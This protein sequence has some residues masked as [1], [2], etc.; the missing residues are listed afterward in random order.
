MKLTIAQPN[1]PENASAVLIDLLASFLKNG[2]LTQDSDLR[3]SLITN[4]VY[5]DS[6]DLLT[7]RF[8]NLTIT[9]ISYYIRFADSNV[10][11]ALLNAN[12]GDG[13]GITTSAAS[14][15][16]IGTLFE[17]NNDIVS[18]NEFKYFRRNNTNTSYKIN[19][20]ANLESIDLSECTYYPGHTFQNLPK[21]EYFGGPNSEP[22]VLAFPEGTTTIGYYGS[23]SSLPKLKH[24]IFPSTMRTF[25]ANEFNGCNN[26][27]SITL[28]EGFQTFGGNSL[29]NRSEGKLII[30]DLDAFLNIT[31]APSNGT[32]NFFNQC[33]YF[34][35]KDSNG[36]LTEITSFTVPQTMLSIP[37]ALFWQCKSL[38][39][40]VFHSSITTIERDA[41]ADCVN[42]IGENIQFPNLTVLGLG[43]FHNC[44]IISF[45]DLGSITT[46]SEYTF[47]SNTSLTTV[48]IPNSV[49]VIKEFAFEG[50]I[51]LVTFSASGTVGELNL[52]N[53]TDLGMFA[54]NDC[55]GM[56][57]IDNL[58]AVTKIPEGTFARCS[59]IASITLNEGL[60]EIGSYA[61]QYTA[62]TSLVIPSTVTKLSGG[63]GCVFG[64]SQLQELVFLATTAPTI[65][66][67]SLFS[68]VPSTCKIYVPDASISSYEAALSVK[69]I[70]LVSRIT[71]MSQRPSS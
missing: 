43:A 46:I 21:L 17:N 25:E 53:L 13:V 57:K 33:P 9:A 14:E 7:N 66:Q 1:T 64:C 37:G 3:G 30:T 58:G 11:E 4:A 40:V 31:W 10:L 50:C 41:F 56:T 24:I 48:H 55:K 6:V 32:K 71:P 27:E 61:F 29:N 45:T 22:G 63:Y 62:I 36:N 12:I 5:Q 69:N 38:R 28:N 42:L 47:S 70:G 2:S 59:N 20:C 67:T 60:I 52:P 39:S 35:L 44:R 23:F 51:H 16:N 18:F 26:I 68:D 8:Q 54:F 34:Y 19:N 65:E 49:S 15:A